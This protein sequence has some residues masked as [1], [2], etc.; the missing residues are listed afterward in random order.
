MRAVI[1]TN[2]L[3][4]SV[5]KASSRPGF[6]VQWIGLHGGLLKSAAVE[7]ELFEVLRRP[8]IAKVAAPI[9]VTAMARLFADAEMVVM[10]ETFAICRDPAD[11]KFLEL[12]VNGRADLIVSGDGDLLALGS[13]RG[14][15]IVT[16]ARFG[17]ACSAQPV[18]AHSIECPG[19]LNITRMSGCSR[20]CRR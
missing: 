13:F 16:P 14:I 19:G 7:Q 4:S 12:A 8:R 20:P 2:V 17:R 6:V 11:D 15:P 9:Q 1:D 10:T 18:Q 5:L 3:I